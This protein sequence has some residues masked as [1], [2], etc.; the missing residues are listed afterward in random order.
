MGEMTNCA[1]RNGMTVWSPVLRIGALQED[2]EKP[3]A[4]GEWLFQSEKLF[5]GAREVSSSTANNI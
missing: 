1:R 4:E 2:K 3:V 5:S